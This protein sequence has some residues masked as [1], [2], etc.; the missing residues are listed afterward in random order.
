MILC[1]GSSILNVM[2]DMDRFFINAGTE[3][4]SEHLF[5]EVG[6]GQAHTVETVT[7]LAGIEGKRWQD[8]SQLGKV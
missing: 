7:T 4:L 1:F 8:C 2:R 3:H 6:G 5:G